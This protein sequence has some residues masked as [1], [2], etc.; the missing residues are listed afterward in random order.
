M[1]FEPL[2][3]EPQISKNLIKAG[4]DQPTEIQANAIPVILEGRDVLGSSQTGTGKTAAFAIPIIQ[5]LLLN[6]EIKQKLQQRDR[7]AQKP[8]WKKGR[9]QPAKPPRNRSNETGPC[10]V[11]ALILSPTRELAI[12]IAATF[13]SLSERTGL[14]I[15]CVFGGVNQYHQVKAFQN[16]VEILVATPGRLLDLINQGHC[17]LNDVDILV[18][19]E[20][21]QMLDLGF[22]PDVRKIIRLSE[23]RSQTLLFSA[24]LPRQIGRLAEEILKTPE[25]IDVAPEQPT[26]EL[27]DHSFYHVPAPKRVDLLAY[28]IGSH[29]DGNHLVF[30]GTKRA[31]DRIVKRL[32]TMGIQAAAIHSDKTQA[33]R[34][35]VLKSFRDGEISVLVAT[36]IAARGIDVKGIHYVVNF[37]LPTSSESYVHRTGRTGR[38]GQR[39]QAISLCSLEDREHFRFLMRKLGIQAN[40]LESQPE[41]LQDL[42]LADYEKRPSGRSGFAPKARQGRRNRN[43]SHAERSRP[44]RSRPKKSS[45]LR[46]VDDSAKAGRDAA[47]PRRSRSGNPVGQETGE[48][49]KSAK[50]STSKR[51]VSKSGQ[52]FDRGDRPERN[53]DEPQ[54]RDRKSKRSP[55]KDHPFEYREGRRSKQRAENGESNSNWKGRGSSKRAKPTRSRAAKAAGQPFV[56]LKEKRQTR[57]KQLI[58]GAEKTKAVRSKRKK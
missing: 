10:A 29:P 55:A 42:R 14:N 31:A 2:G 45:R 23:R 36:D 40:F 25:R 52:N 34:Q 5:K 30:S 58:Q 44:R 8:R 3:L 49:R 53:A 50:R 9:R 54:R 20:A 41:D 22:L 4:F 26:T 24:T 17:T 21:D 47:L 15:G 57:E 18:L 43:D 13:E 39:G 56:T 28:H 12:Q 1:S 37:D 6:D 32:G 48:R 46:S 51:R 33:T 19:D 16:G 11:A 27:I 7:P 35:R 38:A